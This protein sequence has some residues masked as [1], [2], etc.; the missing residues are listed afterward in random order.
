MRCCRHLGVRS[1]P[2]TGWPT[3][4]RE[5]VEHTQSMLNA[6]NELTQRAIERL[7]ETATRGREKWL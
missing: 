3:A 6:T 7:Q 2:S 5:L 4:T 1:R